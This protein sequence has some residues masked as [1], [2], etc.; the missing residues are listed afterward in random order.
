MVAHRDDLRARNYDAAPALQ[1]G[2]M[3]AI[4]N[5]LMTCSPGARYGSAARAKKAK[6]KK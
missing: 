6:S 1:I 3:L 4:V 5:F 2:F